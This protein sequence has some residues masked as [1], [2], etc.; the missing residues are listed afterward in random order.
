MHQ[1]CEVYV[2]T[3]SAAEQARALRLGA[4]WAGDYEARPPRPLDAAITFAPAGDVVVAALRALGRG[5]AVAINAIH[6]DR[7]PEFPYE[8]L[9]WERSLRS[10]ANFT[11]RDALDF[12]QLAATVPIETAAEVLPLTE[13]NAALQ[14]LAA[15]DVSGAFVLQP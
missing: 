14:R 13:A 3:R 8:L 9:W 2:A 1:G 12:L 4:V 10:V 5:G 7:V 15:G 11:R 6:L